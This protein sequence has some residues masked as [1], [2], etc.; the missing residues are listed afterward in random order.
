[1][2][3]IAILT[4]S[5]SGLNLEDTQRLGIYLVPLMVHLDDQSYQ[6]GVEIQVEDILQALKDKKVPKT[7]IRP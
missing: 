7:S 2:S 3:K 5:G 1:M 4:D 6:D